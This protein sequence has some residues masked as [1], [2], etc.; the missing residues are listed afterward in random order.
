MKELEPMKELARAKEI[1]EAL[2]QPIMVEVSRMAAG[3]AHDRRA[4]VLLPISQQADL[5]D[6]FG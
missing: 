5:A 1:L 4:A 6:A 3:E 2:A